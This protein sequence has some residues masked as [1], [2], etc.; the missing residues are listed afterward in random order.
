[1]GVRFPMTRP[2]FVS[3]YTEVDLCRILM[4][5]A[6]WVNLRNAPRNE[7]VMALDPERTPKY[8]Y[9]SAARDRVYDAT[10]MHPA[11]VNLLKRLNADYGTGYT[12]CILNHYA[13][14]HQHLGWHCDDSPEQDPNHPIAVISF[15]AERE[16]WVREKGTKGAVP[17]EDRY[18]L[19][20]GSLFIMPPGFQ[21]THYHKIPKHSCPCG[22]RVSL[23]FRKLDR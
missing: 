16:I 14:E 5:E 13:N 20:S 19:T 15:G 18:L 1:M 11:V 6:Q 4:D 21:D 10:L 7:C 22:D 9:G 17:L 3:N 2:T 23:T 8:T 12:A